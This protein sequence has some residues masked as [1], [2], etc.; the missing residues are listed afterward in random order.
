MKRQLW[1]ITFIIPLFSASS[2]TLAG[3]LSSNLS[4][5]A[6]LGVLGDVGIEHLTNN[7]ISESG[8]PVA[9]KILAKNT[10]STPFVINLNVLQLWNKRHGFIVAITEDEKRL[11]C[12]NPLLQGPEM[13]HPVTLQPGAEEEGS[14]VLTSY[15][16]E[17]TRPGRFEI[18]LSYNWEWSSYILT[19]DGSK[20]PYEKV[21]LESDVLHLTVVGNKEPGEMLSTPLASIQ[22]G[23]YGAHFVYALVNSSANGTVIPTAEDLSKWKGSYAQ[24]YVDALY[25]RHP[26]K[27][28]AVMGKVFEGAS[29]NALA[30]LQKPLGKRKEVAK[31][32][33]PVK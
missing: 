23:D 19:R 18:R 14:I 11:E 3:T 24:M 7:L 13:N 33:A 12:F 15:F 17:L 6:Q 2:L 21:H 8:V 5:H 20:H 28:E 4:I 9:I 1:L 29:S 30:R 31:Y 10:G 27:A 22:D 26:K 25:A 16:P 32:F